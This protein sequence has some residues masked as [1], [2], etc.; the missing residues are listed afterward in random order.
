MVDSA[1]RGALEFMVRF[2]L[3]DV[4]L[5]F[6]LVFTAIFAVLEKSMILGSEKDEY[7]R[8]LSKKNLNAIVA[9]V[10]GFLVVAST[11]LVGI[12]NKLMA[13]VV[14]LIMLGISFLLVIGVFVKDEDDLYKTISG[15]WKIAFM[16]IMFL[17]VLIVFLY[18]MG[19]LGIVGSWF[20]AISVSESLIASIVFLILIAGFIFLITKSSGGTK[21]PDKDKEKED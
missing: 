8:V 18:A 2:G 9:F 14:L 13:N 16:I 21:K 19:W 5:P 7:G 10:I 11:K 3:Y 20:M 1:L 4:I 6:L 15:K 12:L 17:G